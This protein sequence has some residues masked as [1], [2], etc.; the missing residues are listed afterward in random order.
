MN[1]EL[2]KKAEDYIKKIFEGESSGHDYEHSMRVFSTAMN[3]ASKRSDANQ[4]EVGLA[5]LLHDVDDVKLFPENKHY[6]N[7]TT[8]MNNNGVAKDEKIR[9]IHII[10]QISFKGKDTV[11]PDTIEGM[12]VQDADRLDAI[13][14]IGIARAFAYGGSHHRALYIPGEEY[15]KDMSEA[16]YRRATSSTIAHFYEKLL[17]LKNM[18][19]TPEAKQLAEERHNFMIRFLE[20][21]DGEI[22]GER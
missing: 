16:E 5:A 17:L 6:E 20:E 4:E 8:F 21:F 15:R 18:M 11:T 10:S 2:F 13:G 14:A 9:I 19:N 3:I 12:I 7:A 1:T 22:K